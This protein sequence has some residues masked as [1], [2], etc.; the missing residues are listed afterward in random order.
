MLCLSFPL[1]IEQVEVD[2]PLGLL[3]RLSLRGKKKCTLFV[4]C[5]F[6]VC[7]FLLFVACLSV[8]LFVI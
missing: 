5:L 3:A 2:S 4:V 7:Y 1:E 8:C 6:I